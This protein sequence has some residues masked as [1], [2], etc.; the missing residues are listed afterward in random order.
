MTAKKQSKTDAILLYLVER[1]NQPVELSEISSD[2]GFDRKITASI[3]GRLAS[4]GFINKVKR[5]TYVYKEK[6][7]VKKSEIEVICHSLSESIQ[8]TFGDS[9]MKKL[10]IELP[11]KRCK[12]ISELEEILLHLKGA[13]GTKATKDLISVVIETE[14]PRK[15]GQTLMGK[16]DV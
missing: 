14:L 7:T 3:A 10:G 11:L 1:A 5:G 8:K 16:L 2:L 12:T 9:L 6:R 15:S 4:K 13:L